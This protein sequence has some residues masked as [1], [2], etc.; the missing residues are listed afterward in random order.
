[1]QYEQRTEKLTVVSDNFIPVKPLTLADVPELSRTRLILLILNAIGFGA[2][3]ITIITI[4]FRSTDEN[5]RFPE[6]II[7]LPNAFVK[8]NKLE[9]TELEFNRAIEIDP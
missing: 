2:A 9:N 8:L 5:E 4:L 7:K 6:Q 1:M 3:V